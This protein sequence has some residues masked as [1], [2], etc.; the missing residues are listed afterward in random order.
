MDSPGKVVVVD[1]KYKILHRLGEEAV[2]G[3]EKMIES[4]CGAL[5]TCSS[6][7]VWRI[8]VSGSV[9]EDYDAGDH[10]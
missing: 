10:H 8:V 6:L 1:K 9:L 2:G 5:F 4:I 7:L 3:N